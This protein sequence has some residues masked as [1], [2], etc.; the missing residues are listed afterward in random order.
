MY[1]QFIRHGLS[2]TSLYEFSPLWDMISFVTHS[3]LANASDL[4]SPQKIVDK[5]THRQSMR[6]FKKATTATIMSRWR[7][8]RFPEFEKSLSARVEILCKYPLGRRLQNNIMKAPKFCVVWEWEP[9][10][11]I[12]HVSASNSTL[13][14]H[15]LLT[16]KIWRRLRQQTYHALLEKIL[17]QK[18]SVFFERCYPRHS[19]R[20]SLIKS[21]A[22][23]M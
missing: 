4:P 6:D 5:T 17:G 8:I 1:G 21:V 16:E 15:V 7:N 9:L 19:C 22:E 18:G 20:D 23:R 3:R 2:Q 12:I 10:G 11:Q 13:P 14:S